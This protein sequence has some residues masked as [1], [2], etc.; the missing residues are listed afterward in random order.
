VAA[1]LDGDSDGMP[2]SWERTYGLDPGEAGDAAVDTDLD[3]MSNLEEYWVNTNPVDSNSLFRIVRAV[4]EGTG[5]LSVT[6]ESVGGTRYRV[7]FCESV[8]LGAFSFVDIVRPA[9]E[10][11]DPAVPGAR[12]QMSFAESPAVV[13]PLVPGITRFYRIKAVQ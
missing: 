10:E 4:R 13:P 7:Q 6:W 8:S 5:R 12:S 9:A 2:D 1:P 11:I 3:G